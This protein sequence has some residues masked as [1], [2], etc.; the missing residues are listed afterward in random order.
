MKNLLPNDTKISF[1]HFFS[2]SNLKS[3]RLSVYGHVSINIWSLS[4]VWFGRYGSLKSACLVWKI[5]LVEVS[6]FH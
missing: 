6:V 4:Y 2:G 1:L 5:R 3:T